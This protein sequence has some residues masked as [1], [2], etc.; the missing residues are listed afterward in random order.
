M[1]GGYRNQQHLADAVGVAKSTLSGWLRRDDWPVRRKAPW[2]QRDFE[3]IQQWRRQLQEDRSGKG[4]DPEQIDT[5]GGH[6]AAERRNQIRALKEYQQYRKA[7]LEADELE[8]KLVD[9]QVV[10][11]ALTGL[12]ALFVS[13]L[14]DLQESLPHQLA[15]D[16]AQNETT[17]RDRFDDARRRLAEHTEV[18]LSQVED[19]IQAKREGKRGARGRK[20]QSGE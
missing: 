15:G 12:S 18:E 2:S 5:P 19:R 4:A 16:R 17:L 3:A 6:S 8:G 7:K 13:V 14:E 9:R 1:A 11:Q 10:D 20:G